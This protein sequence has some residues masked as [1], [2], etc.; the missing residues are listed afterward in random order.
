MLKYTIKRLLQLIPILFAAS[1]LIFA[2][3]RI[4]PSDPIASM[5]KG[6][7]ISAE[8]RQALEKK[9]YLDKSYPEQYVIWITHA[10]RGDLG[11]S[12]QHKQSVN[13]LI[14]ERIPTTLQLVF[15]S[16][17][18]AIIIAIPV[19]VISAVRMNKLADR[20]LSIATLILVASPVFLTAIVLMIV[21][22]LRLKMFPIFGAGEGFIQNLYYLFLPSLALSLNMVALISR[23][24][25]SNM[26]EQLNSNY[27]TTAIAKGVPY[28]KVVMRH[29]FK[30][31]VIPVITV[32]GIQIG[33]MIVGAVL[34]ENV[35]ALG[36]LGD[37]LISSIKSSD[38]PVVQGITLLLVALFLLI[39]LL[40]DILYAFIDPRI[41]LER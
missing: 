39:N 26:I 23:I 33:A 36:G 27:T 3:V 11:A 40:V 7:K 20:I 34:V 4:S 2:L 31:A 30:N 21:F 6:K 12:F 1:I 35:F 41:R 38:Y 8:T 29:C 32:A 13:S 15:M 19:G 22:A 25:R 28:F 10:I 37:I 16:A 5:T 18:L 17:V 24:M 14:A 9:Y